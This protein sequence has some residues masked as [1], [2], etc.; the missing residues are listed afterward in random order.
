MADGVLY[1]V[2]HERPHF[3]VRTNVIA[4]DEVGFVADAREIMNAEAARPFDLKKGPVVR[5][6]LIKSEIPRLAAVSIVVHHIAIDLRTKD[7]VGE[8][9]AE[10]YAA[11]R[12][13][14]EPRLTPEVVQYDAYSSWSHAWIESEEASKMQ[15]FWQG[16][17][18]GSTHV[19]PL[20]ADLPRSDIQT[21]EGRV[22]SFALGEAFGPE[23]ARFSAE[24]RVDSYVTLLAAYWALLYRYTRCTDFVVGVPLTNRRKAEF[25][26]VMG[27]F[28]N[29]LPLS[30]KV[31]GEASFD[32]LLRT[33]R[34]AML[35]AHRNQEAP[36]EVIVKSV[37]AKRE[38]NRNPL[39][40]V[41]Y[42]FEHPMALKIDG[43]SVE[44]VVCSTGGAQLDLFLR[45]WHAKSGIEGQIEF[46]RDLFHDA[47]AA[48]FV[49]NL[50]T[51]LR[52]A[53][54][55]SQTS[56]D[57]MSLLSSEETSLLARWNDTSRG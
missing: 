31:E 6:A 17:L 28:V 52:S 1:Q 48:R 13:K 20:Y 12:G 3:D 35:G 15:R 37:A 4:G 41:G 57:R 40:Q 50:K 18:E 53:M 9:L 27:C 8:D 10:R 56:I 32:S 33:V 22:A 47:T 55:D 29:T 7:L 19:L 44:Q 25:Q 39:F 36:L 21:S 26:D 46:N 43:V 42:T 11:K 30:I 24:R 34:M 51:L 54:R 16:H 38:A 23:L 5:L 49:K 2:V 14:R 45:C